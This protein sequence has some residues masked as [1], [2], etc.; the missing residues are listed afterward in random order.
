MLTKGF[1]HISRLF[2][3]FYFDFFSHRSVKKSHVT[4]QFYFHNINNT[5]FKTR[6]DGKDCLASNSKTWMWRLITAKKR[7]SGT[8]RREKR[9][10]QKKRKACKRRSFVL[11][12]PTNGDVC[13]KLVIIRRHQNVKPETTRK[14]SI[15]RK[16]K[17]KFRVEQWIT[18]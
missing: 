3:P 10:P 7:T 13:F 8:F 4:W 14:K 9:Q 11:L 12:S 18:K 1:F 6:C 16:H 2:W 15:F 5:R 17:N